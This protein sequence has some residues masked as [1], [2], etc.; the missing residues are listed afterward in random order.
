MHRR[1]LLASALALPWALSA[2]RPQPAAAQAAPRRT[3]A[4]SLLGEPALPADFP[5]FPW[6][7][8]EAPKGGEIALTALGSFDSF[9]PFILRGTPA[10]GIL[11]NVYETLLRDSADEASTAYC[12]LAAAIELAADGLGVTFMLREEARWHD[13]K[14]IT[15][16]D[17]VWTFNTLREQGRPNYRSY[18][19]DVASVAAE[20]P[21]R[22]TFRFKTN[23]NRELALILGQLRVLPK[24]WWEGRDFARPLLDP[25]LGSGPYQLERFEPGRSLVYRRV[26]DY[27]ARDLPTMKGTA[28]FDTMR[29][30]YFRDSTVALEAFKAGQ[31]D[32]RTENVAKDWATAYDFPAVR[33]GLVKLDEIRHELPTGMQAFAMNLRRPLFQDARVRRAL[34]EVFDFEWMNANL[35]YGSY[36]RTTSYF[37]N[38]ELASSGVPEGR[39]KEILEKYRGQLPEKLF[40]EPY[41]LP[42]TDGSGNNREGLRRALDLLR[43]AGWTVRDRRLVNARGE[44]FAFEILLNGPTYERVALPFVQSLQRLGME[45]RVR[46]IDPAQYQVRMDSFD[47]DMTMDVLPQSLSPGNEQRDFFTCAE[48]QKQGSQNIAGICNPVVEELVELV[49]SA[50]DRAELVARTRALDRVLLWQDYMI[51][52]WHSRTFRVAYWDKFGRPPRNPRY[53]LALDSWWVEGGREGAVEQGKREA[54]PQ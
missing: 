19:G 54:R 22:V 44:G 18:Y 40:S 53:A 12:H 43:Q 13:G 11:A 38:S 51:P 8:P 45:P 28:N 34:I 49:I 3:H 37:S 21:K 20:G 24:H 33:R 50:P 47:Y 23:E 17:V 35:F 32:F 6:V 9:N 5:H 16:E 7:N 4:L 25:P 1:D 41:R 26:E 10:V 2:A 15:A 39:E 30:E 31:I 52:N 29:Y 14:P 27:W 36:T 48:A 42:V 46:T